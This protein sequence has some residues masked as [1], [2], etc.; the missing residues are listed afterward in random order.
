MSGRL[1]DRLYAFVRELPR[2]LEE[3]VR[4]VIV[5][6]S[7]ARS[8]DFVP[9]LSDVDVL[10]LVEGLPR[11]R[12]YYFDVEGHEVNVVVY[13][14]DE[15][16]ALYSA[17]DP[18]AHMLRHSL[19][20]YDSG[21]AEALPAEAEVT[22]HTLRALR[23]SVFAALGLAVEKYFAGF[24]REAASHVYHSARY[25][26]RYD[27]VLRG[28]QFPVSDAEVRDAASGELEAL[29]LSSFEARKREV[30]R[31][32]AA[33]LIERAIDVLCRYLGLKPTTLRQLEAAAWGDALT[34]MACEEAGS[35]VFK[36]E[37]Y[38]ENGLKILKVRGEGVEEAENLVC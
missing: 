36:V 12:Y 10:V 24:Y 31:V 15:L 18:L 9:G 38:L 37:R 21:L 26:A 17:G 19:V 28:G 7:A 5:F 8:E 29:F 13:T 30:T 27:C 14:F 4:S 16:L 33:A 11:R 22:G 1:L 32:E 20:V 23:R 6:G 35:L 34:V 3:D 2:L 25:L